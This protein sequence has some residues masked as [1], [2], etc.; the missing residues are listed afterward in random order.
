MQASLKEV[1]SRL[2]S[3]GSENTRKIYK[4]HGASEPMFGV[5]F[6]DLEKIRKEIKKNHELA[7]LLWNTGNTDA[8]TLA[9]MVAEPKKMSTKEIND[10]LKVLSYDTLIDSFTKYIVCKHEKSIELMEAWIDDTDEW[11]ARAGYGVFISLAMKNTFDEQYLEKRLKIIVKTID[12]A[13]N[14]V[15]DNMINAV[16]AIGTYSEQMEKAAREAAVL[17]GDVKIDYGNNSCK[18][19]DICNYL[20]KINERKKTKE[21]KLKESLAK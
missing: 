21:K 10:W 14:R 15:K 5:K 6:G 1:M 12:K 9:V 13:K 16:I 7:V 11:I 17:I 18:T 3:F 20:D 4:N 2:E 8:M 19:P